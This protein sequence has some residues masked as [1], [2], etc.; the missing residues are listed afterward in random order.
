MQERYVVASPAR[1][2]DPSPDNQAPVSPQALDK[3]DWRNL[4]RAIDANS[5]LPV[6]GRELSIVDDE[7]APTRYDRALARRLAA[8]LDVELGSSAPPELEDVALAYVAKNP[9]DWA[10]VCTALSDV[11]AG[12]QPAVP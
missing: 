8:E 9:G 4:V 1:G 3:I 6:I 12:Y 11:M 10:S 2:M 7:G 5:V